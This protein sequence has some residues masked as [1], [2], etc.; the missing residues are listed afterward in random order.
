[1]RALLKTY[2][3]IAKQTRRPIYEKEQLMIALTQSPK[4]PEAYFLL[5][6]WQQCKRRMDRSGLLC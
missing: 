2:R 1:M 5:S 4:R 6:Q 3:C